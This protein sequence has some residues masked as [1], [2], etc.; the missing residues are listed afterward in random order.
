VSDDAGTGALMG[1]I[2]RAHRDALLGLP[3]TLRRR[4]AERTQRTLGATEFVR[5][6]RRDY[7]P[8]RT[9]VNLE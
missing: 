1:A 7:L 6:W 4:H 3:E 2:A 5:R 9:A 8:M